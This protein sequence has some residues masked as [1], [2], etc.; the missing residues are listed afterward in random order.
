[1]HK[2]R[3]DQCPGIKVSPIT[4]HKWNNLKQRKSWESLMDEGGAPS[5]D[6]TLAG[7]SR[8]KAAMKSFKQVRPSS[9]V[10]LRKRSLMPFARAIIKHQIA[11][12]FVP[13]FSNRAR[14]NADYLFLGRLGC[15][16]QACGTSEVWF[17]CPAVNLWAYNFFMII[18]LILRLKSE[19]HFKI[20]KVLQTRVFITEMRTR[21][22]KC[23]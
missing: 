20:M 14:E 4:R 16:R 11:R 6:W 3:H 21:V 8:S 9:M 17:S 5:G 15:A 2:G 18:S 12:T 22:V 19:S 23:C 1:M 7:W 10:D 13:G